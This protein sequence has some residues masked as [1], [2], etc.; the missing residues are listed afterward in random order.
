MLKLFCMSDYKKKK[1]K[2][3]QRN[4]GQLKPITIYD[5][6]I[7]EDIVS[8]DTTDTY[9]IRSDRPKASKLIYSLA[10]AIWVFIG[11]G[12]IALIA[13][14]IFI[15]KNM[16]ASM[17]EYHKEDLIAA[18]S[19]VI[20]DANGDKV[21]ELGVFLRDNITYGDLPE[22]LINS[23]Q[24][25]EDSRF[26]EHNGF[27][28]P[29]FLKALIS[30]LKSGNTSQ[31]GSTLDMQLLKNTYF[32]NDLTQEMPARSGLEG[33]ARKLQE[34][35]L[36][37]KA[38][39]DNTK[40]EILAHYL[41]R[42]NF[43]N[44]IRGI[45]KASEYYFGKHTNELNLSESALLSGLINL[46]NLYNPYN[47][48]KAATLKRD[49]T[50]DAL[51][52][53]G[54]ITEK[55]A[56]L[57]KSIKV[58]DLLVGV[59]S[60]L[61]YTNPSYQSYIDAVINET[62]AVTGKD[63]QYHSMKIYTAMDPYMQKVF[64]NIQ[65]DKYEDI[66][67]ER[68]N[69]QNALVMLNNKNGRI[70]ALGGGR[71]Q[72]IGSSRL[73]NRATDSYIS[74]GSS[75]KPFMDYALTFDR[76]GWASTHT[77]TDRPIFYPQTRIVVSN[78]NRIYLGDMFLNEAL[79]N[80][81]NTPA[82][83]ALQS[84]VEGIGLDEFMKYL[85]D[86]GFDV[87]KE[88]FDYQYALGG[89]TFRATPVQ[90]AA[91]HAML[92]NNGKYIKPHTIQKIEFQSSEEVFVSDET[93]KQVISPAAAYITAQL[94]KEVV[95]GPAFNNV[96]ILGYDRNYTVYAKTGTSD[97]AS[98]GYPYGIPFGAAKDLLLSF[99]NNKY[100]YFSWLGFDKAV[101]G[102]MSWFSQYD[103]NRNIRAKIA[104]KVLDEM[105]QHYAVDGVYQ[106]E[107][108]KRPD[109]VEEIT[110]IVGVFPYATPSDGHRSVTGLIDKRY[111]KTVSLSTIDLSQN[112]DS[113]SIQNFNFDARIEDK[114]I[115][116][117]WSGLGGCYNGENGLVKDISLNGYGINIQA[118]GRCYFGIRS[119]A[120]FFA[121]I[122]HNGA[123]VATIST[124]S[125]SYTHT[126]GDVNGSIEVCGYAVIKGGAT[127]T[128]CIKLK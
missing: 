123:P 93:G 114:S 27:D 1:K 98:D 101:E 76:L 100:T 126:I 66:D 44:R 47:N 17:P 124:D 105:D 109:D 32:V 83:Q 73:L 112:S 46:P 28:I 89:Y 81:L 121:T 23:F 80:S 22:N 19:S 37:F 25:I 87:S 63:P 85:T 116:L 79:E 111:N 10:I 62:I 42:L 52:Y 122:N 58:E 117:N 95:Y 6:K 113:G 40:Q 103:I 50:L 82:V 18:E 106:V 36:S 120:N 55:E 35:I 77:I 70:V 64:Y 61:K 34:V 115:V 30:N 45:E 38:N 107:D 72:E 21:I 67:F 39:K 16:L 11:I 51:V 13:G 69:I 88:D 78:F 65:N 4:I 84:V 43:G 29:R 24:S 75:V 41:N 14:F 128:K 71:H 3:R 94:E 96:D 102:E 127:E 56:N 20:Y 91:A 110:H 68:D 118:T 74:P 54:Y 60:H 26:F 125:S 9:L 119:N 92:L 49:E 53:H 104:L 57:A 31:G 48:L 8:L 7:D 99:S 108:V 33:Y 15:Q 90:M 97:W 5:L 12:L 86:I 2:K 59:K